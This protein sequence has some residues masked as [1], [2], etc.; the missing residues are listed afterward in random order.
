MNTA[1][2]AGPYRGPTQRDIEN[3]V[4]RICRL[5]GDV[6]ALG[7]APVV[8]HAIGWMVSGGFAAPN[9]ELT[10]EFWLR[11]TE[12]MMLRCDVLVLAPDWQESAGACAERALWLACRNF[13]D[14]YDLADEGEWDRLRERGE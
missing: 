4:D 12:A 5:A 8:P 6:A 14:C 13:R 1:Y 9:P 3:N 11:A 7:I 10:D 2:I